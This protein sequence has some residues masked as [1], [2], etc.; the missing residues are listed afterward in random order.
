MRITSE[1]I[2]KIQKT[3]DE[4]IAKMSYK[5]KQSYFKKKSSLVKIFYSTGKGHDKHKQPVKGKPYI[6]SKEVV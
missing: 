3:T 1:E 2:E 6:K 4:D 5:D